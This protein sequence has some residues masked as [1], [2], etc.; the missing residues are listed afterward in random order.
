MSGGAWVQ[1]LEGKFVAMIFVPYTYFKTEV[2]GL[3]R[4]R[5]GTSL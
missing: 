4:R 1:R 3:D 2:S 5:F